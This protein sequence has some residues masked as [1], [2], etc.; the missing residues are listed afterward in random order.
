MPPEWLLSSTSSTGTVALLSEDL[1]ESR[2][3]LHLDGAHTLKSTLCCIRWFEQVCREEIASV[4]A[5]AHARSLGGGDGSDG[6]LSAIRVLIYN[7]SHERNVG[8]MLSCLFKG[9]RD[10]YSNEGEERA[11]AQGFDAVLFCPADYNRPT[12]AQLPP[13]SE[14]MRNIG[15]STAP[16]SS[17]SS[18]TGSTTLLNSQMDKN[19]WQQIMSSAWNA[20][21]RQSFHSNEKC[22]CKETDQQRLA[23]GWSRVCNNIDDALKL[24]AQEA[25]MSAS[26]IDVLVTGSLYLIGGVLQRCGWDPDVGFHRNIICDIKSP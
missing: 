4:Q 25:R 10:R 15:V 22:V 13:L 14:V 9:N 21:R 2:V 3:R 26:Q 6:G 18:E 20:L 17:S 1:V 23:G 16:E 12:L 8:E 19:A 24:V 5:A 11:T 7:C